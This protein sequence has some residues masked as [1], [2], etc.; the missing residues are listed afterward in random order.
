MVNIL[1]YLSVVLIC[2]HY[3]GDDDVPLDRFLHDLRGVL[4]RYARGG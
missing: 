4:K 2:V 3:G 1:Y